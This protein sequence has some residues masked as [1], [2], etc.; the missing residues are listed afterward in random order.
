MREPFLLGLT[1]DGLLGGLSL[2]R[3]P[4]PG[5]GWSSLLSSLVMLAFSSRAAVVV[6][7]ALLVCGW[8]EYVDEIVSQRAEMV[9]LGGPGRWPRWSW[10]G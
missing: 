10:W 7:G 1:H 3:P 8:L 6:I 2:P 4:P 9:G 5:A